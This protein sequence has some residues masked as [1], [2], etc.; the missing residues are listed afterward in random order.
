MPESEITERLRL[1]SLA[2][3]TLNLQNHHFVPVRDPQ[4][5]S[6]STFQD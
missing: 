4:L 1:A 6:Q 5:R 3:S 2:P